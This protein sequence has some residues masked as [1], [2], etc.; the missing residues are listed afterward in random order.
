MKLRIL[1]LFKIIFRYPYYFFT[2]YVLNYI[3]NYIPF[4]WL[5]HFYYKICGMKICGGSFINMSQIVIFPHKI[6]IGN[7]SHIN[8]SCLLDGRGGIKIGSKV[9]ISFKVNLLTGSHLPNSNDFKYVVKPIIIEDFVWIGCGATIL[10]GVTIG[11]GSVVSA[12]SVVTRDIP[13]MTIVGGIPAKI[14]RNRESSLNY[15]VSWNTPF[16]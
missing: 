15:D 3:V 5:R 11:R 2:Y 8:R 4:W 9:S 1:N 7:H 10:P 14:L 6:I 13:P 12:G 16:Y